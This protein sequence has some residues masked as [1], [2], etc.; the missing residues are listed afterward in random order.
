M[1]DPNIT[2]LRDR[3][4][5]VEE[6]LVETHESGDGA[7]AVY[8]DPVTGRLYDGYGEDAAPVEEVPDVARLVIHSR[9]MSMERTEAR[10]EGYEIVETLHEDD[11]RLDVVSVRVPHAPS[12]DTEA[13]AV[14]PDS[15]D[16]E[17]AA[18]FQETRT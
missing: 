17:P 13:A 9:T 8:E 16:Q 4:E 15:A 2:D 18:N 7:A 14:L 10:D 11:P 3:L 1:S 6:T 5:D 12:V